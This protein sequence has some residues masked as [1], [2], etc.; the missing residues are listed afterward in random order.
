MGMFIKK[1]IEREGM[2]GSSPKTMGK[3]GKS[4][5]DQKKLL[6]YT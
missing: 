2:V 5:A 4:Y 3:M 6:H 1:I